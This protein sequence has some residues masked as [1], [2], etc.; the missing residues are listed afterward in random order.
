MQLR[1]CTPHA[2]FLQVWIMQLATVGE[3]VKTT[4]WLFRH[5]EVLEIKEIIM[6]M[7]SCCGQEMKIL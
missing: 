2:S 3:K 7:Y 1:S 6:Y 4:P 5:A